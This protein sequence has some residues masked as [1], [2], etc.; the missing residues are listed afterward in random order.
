MGRLNPPFSR[1]FPP[2]SRRF[3][4]FP[5]LTILLPCTSKLEKYTKHWTTHSAMLHA[6]A[7]NPFV[8]L[9]AVISIV[10]PRSSC[11]HVQR[12]LE[13][14]TL[15][16]TLL[17]TGYMIR[18]RHLS[19]GHHPPFPQTRPPVESPCPPDTC[20]QEMSSCMFGKQSSPKRCLEKH[21]GKTWCRGKQWLAQPKNTRTERWCVLPWIC[22]R[23]LHKCRTMLHNQLMYI[24][25]SF[26]LQPETLWFFQVG[27]PSIS[28]ASLLVLV[29]PCCLSQVL[30]LFCLELPERKLPHIP[31]ST[32][33][34]C[35]L[36][37]WM[38]IMLHPER[39]SPN[40]SRN[41]S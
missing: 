18:S 15:L 24:Q 13:H 10:C 34:P 4:P 36:V 32:P 17:S 37:V 23:I 27:R 6:S 40:L 25:N 29:F 19:T 5:K 2:F 14:S 39:L 11:T 8:Q 22:R 21:L 16:L 7:C 41:S 1:R 20:A 31:G 9:C 30:D 38:R 3:P 28:R 33:Q 26:V 12:K 35:R